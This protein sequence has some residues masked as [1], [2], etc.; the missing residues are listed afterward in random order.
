MPSALA[1]SCSPSGDDRALGHPELNNQKQ[2][3][4]TPRP[5]R[6]SLQ[7]IDKNHTDGHSYILLLSAC[8]GDITTV[9]VPL[10]GEFPINNF[11]LD[12]GF[13][14]KIAADPFGIIM[15][16][17]LAFVFL[18]AFGCGQ[19]IPAQAQREN[20]SIGENGQEARKA[21]KQQRKTVNKNAKRQRKAAKK[22]QKAQSK[23]AK[24]Q[25][26]RSK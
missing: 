13:G 7:K 16:R 26:H 6:D 15:K 2:S 18:L 12:I 14:V 9:L 21:A 22:Y 20:R 25:Q 8:D 24:Q 1:L 10:C 23:S 17:I 11:L 19:G 4:Y 5:Y 3:E